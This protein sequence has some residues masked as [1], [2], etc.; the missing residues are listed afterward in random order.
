VD[1]LVTLVTRWRCPRCSC[2]AVTRGLVPNRFHACPGLHGLTAPLAREGTDC[3]ITATERG[4]YLNGETATCGDDGRPYM[5]VETRHAD[6]HT[7]LVVFAPCA[8][9]DLRAL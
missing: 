9:V 8:R 7:D 1:T 5:N 3:E 2:T 6:G 4:D